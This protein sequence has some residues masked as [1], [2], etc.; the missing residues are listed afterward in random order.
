MEFQFK[1]ANCL[2]LQTKKAKIVI[3]DNLKELGV[4]SS[5]VKA[6]IAIY[7][8]KELIK[9]HDHGESFVIEGPGEYE[10]SEVSV[11]GVAARAHIDEESAHNA[12]VYRLAVGSTMICIVGH[13][14]PKLSDEQLE[15]LGMIDILI[16]PVGGNGYTMDA[17]GAE[18][19]IKKIDP[20]I[21][22]PTHY[23]DKGV[24]YE[25]P[26]APLDEFIKLMAVTPEKVDKLKFKTDIFPENLVVYQLERS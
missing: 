1:G 5:Q 8:S 16:I 19:L 22:I 11:K 24:N 26:Q 17:V 2:T 14:F 23:D 10:I 21:V 9:N 25:V 4:A 18:K 7:T 12:T 6:D 20:K 15:Q 3:D 13:I